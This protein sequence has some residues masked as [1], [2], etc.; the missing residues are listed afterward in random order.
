MVPSLQVKRLNLSA[1][2]PTRATEQSAGYDLYAN[3]DAV[4][5]PRDKALIPL[6]LSM[7]FPRGVYGRITP[8]SGLAAKY[9]INV[10]A[11]VIDADY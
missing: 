11:G 4:I 3:T 9:M 6:S 2:L 7:T 10:G 8:R 1:Q 5:A